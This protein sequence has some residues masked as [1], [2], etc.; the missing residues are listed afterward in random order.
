MY[1]VGAVS[2]VLMLIIQDALLRYLPHNSHSITIK[3]KIQMQHDDGIDEAMQIMNRNHFNATGQN[4]F[5][6]DGKEGWFLI[7]EAVSYR[8]GSAEE[9][10][11]ELR[12]SDRIISVDVL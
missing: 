6:S 7:C 1:I 2:T 5:T 4:H 9:L 10:L 11:A 3:L 8:G 12:K